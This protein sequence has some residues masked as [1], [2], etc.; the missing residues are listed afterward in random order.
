M[1]RLHNEAQRIF[2]GLQN[3]ALS[4]IEEA[5]QYVILTAAWR[6]IK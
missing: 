5:E 1:R 6:Q 2:D 3:H 4:V